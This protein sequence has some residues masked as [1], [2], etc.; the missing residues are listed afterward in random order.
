MDYAYAFFAKKSELAY[1]IVKVEEMDKAKKA[2]KANGIHLADE[3]E[4]AKL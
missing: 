1:M 3:N 2:F 4:I